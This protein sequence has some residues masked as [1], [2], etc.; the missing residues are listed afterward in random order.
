[1]HAIPHGDR[2]AALR[3]SKRRIDESHESWTP[4][5]VLDLDQFLVELENSYVRASGLQKHMEKKKAIQKI[6][7]SYWQLSSVFPGMTVIS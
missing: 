5:K 2:S 4:S 1:M 6:L 7:D 3:R